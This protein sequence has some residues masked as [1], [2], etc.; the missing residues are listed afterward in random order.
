MVV[1]TNQATSLANELLTRLGIRNHFSL[2]LGRD[3]LQEP[4]PSPDGLLEAAL[5]LHLNPEQLM[6]V[7]GSVNDVNA[8]RAAGCGVVCV[9]HA[10]TM[11]W[12]SAMQR[13]IWYSKRW[14]N[15]P[16]IWKQKNHN[17]QKRGRGDRIPLSLR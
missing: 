4:K 17:R 15:C 7:G 13:Q 1:V 6:V 14:Q 5:L 10:I 16:P 3:A 2:I 12:T 11:A 9:S 8:A